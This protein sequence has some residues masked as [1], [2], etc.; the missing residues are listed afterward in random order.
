MVLDGSSRKSTIDYSLKRCLVKSIR[1]ANGEK[2][3]GSRTLGH[4]F[5]A[6]V[7][8]IIAQTGNWSHYACGDKAYP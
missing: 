2:N 3:R 4:A 7:A 8:D 6:L 1:Q 5:D